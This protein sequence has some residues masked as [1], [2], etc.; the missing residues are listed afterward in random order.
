M[1]TAV[2]GETP[3]LHCGTRWDPSQRAAMVLPSLLSVGSDMC[4]PC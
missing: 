2:G 4:G 3:T 1:S